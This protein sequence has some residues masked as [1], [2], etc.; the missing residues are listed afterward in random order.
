VTVFRPAREAEVI[1]IQYV[2]EIYGR[3]DRWDDS[4]HHSGHQIH[5]QQVVEARVVAEGVNLIGRHQAFEVFKEQ[6]GE[7][8]L[9]CFVGPHIKV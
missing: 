8:T 6:F 5:Q 1:V 7:C 4:T 9:Q 2:T 3:E